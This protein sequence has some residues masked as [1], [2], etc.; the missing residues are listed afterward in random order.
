MAS[1]VK[2]KR[3]SVSG[4]VPTIS[5][6]STGELALNINDGKLYSTDG[7]RVFE[8]GANTSSL[9]INDSYTF[10][11]SDGSENQVLTTNGQ[12]DLRF[13]AAS[14]SDGG[15]GDFPFYKNDNLGGN[16]LDE[17]I[18]IS[19]LFTFVRNNGANDSIIVK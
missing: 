1:V 16:T 18:V 5:D 19:G 7:L 8:V 10:P 9:K 14:G 2:I 3:S 12:G 15:G 11:V 6:I 17:I 13:A 4:K